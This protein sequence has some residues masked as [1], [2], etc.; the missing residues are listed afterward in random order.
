MPSTVARLVTHELINPPRWLAPNIHYETM[1][2]SVAYGVSS[3]T[4]DVDLYGFCIPPKDIL[5]PHLAGVITGFG[6]Q[7]ES[8]NEFQQHHIKDVGS[9]KVYDVT[10]YNIAKYFNLCMDNNPN[11]ID[12][13]FTPQFC[14]LHATKV[15]QMVREN[16][17]LFLH[18]GAWHKFK[19]YAYSQL[20]KMTTKE[21]KGKRVE[22]R[23]KFGFDVKFAY[24]VVRLLYEVEM[25]MT[26]HTIDLQRHREHLKSIRRGEVTEAEIRR[27]ATDKEASLE[28]VYNESTLQYSPDEKAIKTLLVNCLEEHYG[29]LTNCV[30]IPDAPKLALK[31]I[32]KILDKY[33]AVIQ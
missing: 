7:G 19:G 33:S 25:I 18:K 10:I 26:E 28:K 27:W 2:G 11:M 4:S 14:V 29:S 17:N 31:E 3:D 20:H 9:E 8:F 6:N 21:P 24:H 16:R 12:S 32:Q 5:F 15:G 30:V 23:E 22:L 1:M 13:L